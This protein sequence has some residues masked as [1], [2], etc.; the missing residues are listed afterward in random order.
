MNKK[1][2][3]FTLLLVVP[4]TFLK[5]QINITFTPDAT[6]T[7]KSIIHEMEGNLSTVLTEI[8]S[9]YKDNRAL[10]LAGLPMTQFAKG[11]LSKLWANSLFY[12]KDNNMSTRIWNFS[13]GYMVRQVP[14]MITPRDNSGSKE[15]FQEA[16]VEFDG[17]GN[18]SDFKFA[19]LKQMGKSLEHAGNTEEVKHKI[20]ILSYCDRLR[21]AYNTRD[22]RFFQQFFRGDTLII[23]GQANDGKPI[24]SAYNKEYVNTLQNIFAK[25]YWIEVK[26]SEI[27]T[28]DKGEASSGIIRSTKNPNLY[29]VRFQQEWIASDYSDESYV[30]LLFDF[31][32]EDAPAIPVR[33]LAPVWVGGQKI[34]DKELYSIEDFEK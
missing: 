21:T 5:A 28:N 13:N 10:N 32:N 25:R 26:F 14:L 19:S 18:I 15:V 22:I 12:C 2:L 3:L 31:T 9:A 23:K 17:S 20:A 11:E 7:N 24:S 29:A 27:G 4:F 1:I 30:F 16:V 33:I 6:V 8:N 34:S